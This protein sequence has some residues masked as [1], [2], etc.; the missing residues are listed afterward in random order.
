MGDGT[1]GFHFSEFETAVRYKLPIIV[2]IGNDKCWNAEHQIQ[3]RKYG[4]DRLIGCELSD[5]RYDKAVEALGGYGELVTD[6]KK[7]ESSLKRAK[8]SKKPSCLNVLI[9]GQSAPILK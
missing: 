4:K 6:I 5:A 2:I 9:N 7:L 8:N 3:V 1:A